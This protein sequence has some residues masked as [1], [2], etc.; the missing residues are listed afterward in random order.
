VFHPLRFFSVD[1]VH[2]SDL[3]LTFHKPRVPHE[4]WF[5]RKSITW[6]CHMNNVVVEIW[7]FTSLKKEAVF[8]SET[9]VPTY[10]TT[11]WVSRQDHSMKSVWNIKL[12]LFFWPITFFSASR[13]PTV[14]TAFLK[15]H[16]QT[17]KSRMRASCVCP[18]RW[19]TYPA[20]KDKQQ[21]FM[22]HT[23]TVYSPWIPDLCSMSAGCGMSHESTKQPELV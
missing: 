11:W 6:R 17:F 5:N 18:A 12:F 22:T 21:S 3:P 13:I 1:V 7:L 4:A 2:I 19:F 15:T 23:H 20:L 9:L 10:Q 8:F 14:D 16:T